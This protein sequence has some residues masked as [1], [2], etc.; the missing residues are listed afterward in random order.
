MKRSNLGGELLIQTP[1]GGTI[2][3]SE[4][5]ARTAAMQAEVQ[6]SRTK[7]K[8]KYA[9]LPPTIYTAEN[10]VEKGGEHFLQVAIGKKTILLPL[11]NIGT[12]SQ[13]TYI[14]V[15]NPQKRAV[16]Q[17]GVEVLAH[18]LKKLGVKLVITPPSSKSE[19]MI[20]QATKKA[21][22]GQE[23]LTIVGGSINGVPAK[24]ILTE[25]EVRN[26]VNDGTAYWMIECRPITLGP[27]DPSKFFGINETMLTRII[28]QAQQ[29]NPIVIVDDV[30]SS[31]ATI[32]AIKRL[33][34]NA[35][36]SK[37][38]AVPHM[39]IAVVAEERPAHLLEQ[40]AQEEV[41]SEIV[42][43]VLQTI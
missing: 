11:V 42:I 1:D 41:F 39:S 29:G 6:K 37:G 8:D 14:A 34:R 25:T 3:Y 28:V 24:R 43:P 10:I 5:Q 12:E 21:R 40:P 35:L 27:N 38:I 19:R 20:Y 36:Q 4:A 7:R 26:M 18:M 15:L 2:T 31:G 23:P 22:V 13:P 9:L 16:E 30:Y 33:I 17:A 32:A